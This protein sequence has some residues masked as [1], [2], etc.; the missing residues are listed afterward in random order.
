MLMLESNMTHTTHFC[1]FCAT[2]YHC[3]FCVTRTVCIFATDLWQYY[4]IKMLYISIHTVHYK[5]IKICIV[6]AFKC[7]KL[8]WIFLYFFKVMKTKNEM[9]FYFQVLFWHQKAL[10]CKRTQA[11]GHH[12][13]LCRVVVIKL[14]WIWHLCWCCSCSRE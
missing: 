11:H 14:L 9:S 6:R 5:F 4:L 7:Q 10:Q 13:A 2:V 12:V 1:L 8:K 3:L